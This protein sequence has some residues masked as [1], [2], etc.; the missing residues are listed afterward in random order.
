MDANI[1]PFLAALAEKVVD[2]S[3]LTK[4]SFLMLIC[5]E[6]NH[7]HSQ[8]SCFIASTLRRFQDIHQKRFNIVAHGSKKIRKRSASLVE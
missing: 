2:P 1:L 4:V 6:V 8:I 7:A 3:L 5:A